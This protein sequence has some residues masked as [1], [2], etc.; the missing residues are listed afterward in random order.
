[1]KNID[2]QRN[3]P[4]MLSTNSPIESSC[5]AESQL[6]T[7]R[8]LSTLSMF[9]H[10]TLVFIH[11][12]L[13][14]VSLKRLEHQVVFSVEDQKNASFLIT[15]IS[16][17]VDAIYS[18]TLVFLTQTLSMRRSFRAHQALTATHDSVTAWAG[19]GSALLQL[20]R[21]RT[22]PSSFVGVLST[23]L[24]LGNISI[25]HI[26]TP[27]L[28]AAQTFNSTSSEP[29]QT[30]G[31]P[32]F[33]FSM[34]DMSNEQDRS[35]AWKDMTEYAQGSLSSFG[36]TWRNATTLGLHGGT[37]YD[38]FHGQGIGNIK[39]NAT[40]F[41][42]TC[43]YIP[44]G[45][46]LFHPF[47]TVIH[48]AGI[49]SQVFI[50]NGSQSSDI[51]LYS[52]IPIID[53]NNNIEGRTNLSGI[54]LGPLLDGPI[55][56][57]QCSQS[58]V[59][60]TA[61]V[62]SG[63]QR[64]LSAKPGIDKTVALWRSTSGLPNWLDSSYNPLSDPQISYLDLWAFWYRS[65]PLSGFG[66]DNAEVVWET[67]V[68]LIQQ[69]NL[70][71]P[72]NSSIPRPSNISLYQLENA[73]SSLVATMFWN[74]AQIPFIRY[75]K[76]GS[77]NG[78]KINFPI[79]GRLNPPKLITGQIQMSRQLLQ[80]RLEFLHFRVNN[81]EV[82]LDGAGM[83]HAIWLYRDHHELTTILKHVE[84]PT[85]IKLRE[86]GMLRATLIRPWWRPPT[87]T[88]R[89]EKD[90][91]RAGF[92]GTG[93]I[94]ALN[95]AGIQRRGDSHLSTVSVVPERSGFKFSHTLKGLSLVLHG[96]LVT[97]HL[98]LV[99]I[100]GE[101]KCSSDF[102][103]QEAITSQTIKDLYIY[104]RT[105]AIFCNR[106]IGHI[107][108]KRNVRDYRARPEGAGER[109]L[110]FPVHFASPSNTIYSSML[111]FLTQT[112][113]TRRSIRKTQSLTVTHDS[114][115]AWAGIGSAVVQI[116]R[117]KSARASIPGVL[118]IFLYLGN[119][120][121]LSITTPALFSLETFHSSH[122][123]LVSTQSLPTFDFS[124]YNMSD[125][126]DM[127][128]A[129]S[130]NLGLYDGPLYD[131]LEDTGIG[132][133]TVN[134]TWFNITCRYFTDIDV[135][136]SGVGSAQPPCYIIDAI[137]PGIITTATLSANSGPLNGLAL[138]LVLYSSIP[139]LDSSGNIGHSIKPDTPYILIEQLNLLPPQGSLI[140]RASNI[141]LHELENVLSSY[142]ALTF[143]TAGHIPP[144]PDY[145]AGGQYNGTSISYPTEQV[146]LVPTL[147][148]GE[149]LVPQEIIQIRP[150]VSVG[151]AVSIALIL[152]S[153]Q[154]SPPGT[155]ENGVPIEGTGILH[156][157][158]LYR[159]HPELPKLLEQ[160]EHPTDDN[161]RKAG[162][163]HHIK[164]LQPSNTT[165]TK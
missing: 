151:L 104:H 124:E 130:T 21:Q 148:K 77:Y 114:A 6:V 165:G 96:M 118:S 27:A 102:A 90:D 78:T 103:I 68:Y 12:V 116:W 132:N 80:A 101:A 13:I 56:L 69:L 98:L 14:L 63:S 137:Q 62:D 127:V 117:Q 36:S 120:L 159:N 74:L 70:F 153:L 28:F 35:N 67:D 19:I 10:T 33:D 135:A 9:L 42:I 123:V 129:C 152:L 115:T 55:Q 150:N 164:L 72:P 156:S 32:T 22:L 40:G 110:R 162:M 128:D 44:D 138:D 54:N 2:D 52:S 4:M 83:L 34:Y 112:L 160:V 126:Q 18:A 99:V 71:P 87:S 105:R 11:L 92:S 65:M 53:S 7:S 29:V 155:A 113:A 84:H 15:A 59:R 3:N 125:P 94:Q 93:D 141:T 131:V 75:T 39:F 85:D 51:I 157:I 91:L 46:T 146:R 158:W 147:A 86:A 41:N 45:D 66:P 82:P 17:T 81:E 73:L 38:T 133:A 50:G 100:N 16:T 5:A 134:A 145:A 139:V 26:T 149:A 136:V 143:W 89:A 48:P 144:V 79:T 95:Q 1:M 61:L 58:L 20:W 109:I 122:S 88:C 106:Q 57:L 76:G 30:Q 43:R 31:L 107:T 24:Y 140:P 121:L 119:I 111:V 142:V 163:V 49:V 161:L 60:Q 108:W 8:F 47:A 154:F 97:T 25:L 23:F 64:L 37:L